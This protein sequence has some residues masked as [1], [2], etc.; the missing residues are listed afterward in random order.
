[1][2][3]WQRK[4][5]P[6]DPFNGTRA[7]V[8]GGTGFV[9]RWVARALWRRG[10]RVS[11][12]VSD[13]ERGRQMLDD[14]DIGGEIFQI[15]LA[16]PGAITKALTAL[17]PAVT[18]N[19]VGYGV[20]PTER[21]DAVAQ[22]INADLVPEIAQAVATLHDP[23]AWH[24]ARLVH[25]GSAAEYGDLQGWLRETSKPHPTTVYGR[26]KLEGTRKLAEYC[27]SLGMKALT[28]RL[29]TVYGPGEHDGR[30][31]PALLEA[32]RTGRPLPLTA[33]TQRR[34]FTYVED[35]AEGLLRLAV[36][37]IRP[38]EVVNLAT[39]RL[40][41]VRDFVLAAADIL[42]IPSERLQFGALPTRAD[43]MRQYGVDVTQLQLLTSWTPP[44]SMAD[45]IRLTVSLLRQPP[46]PAGGAAVW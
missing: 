46:R 33:G 9:G 45:G 20:D 1:M 17:R 16:E 37:P 38:G 44:T 22:R 7:L 10:A 42:Q 24:A 5:L 29:F 4:R 12:V 41:T 6:P 36:S 11:L 19:L 13:A 23:P 30:L 8:L 32:E 18:F 2:S 34:D 39:G 15:D 35:V 25:A 14:F 43:E 26:T 21:D 40:T 3:S 31:L 28:A 27:R